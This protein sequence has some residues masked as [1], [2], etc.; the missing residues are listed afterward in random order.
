MWWKKNGEALSYFVRLA[1]FGDCEI[2]F[3]IFGL[4]EEGAQFEKKE[5]VCIMFEIQVFAYTVQQRQQSQD[6]SLTD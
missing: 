2:T 4:E 5:W 6:Y 1:L 3:G